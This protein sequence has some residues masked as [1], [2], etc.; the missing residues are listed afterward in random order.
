MRQFGSDAVI[1]L[2]RHATSRFYMEGEAVENNKNWNI[3][4]S[5]DFILVKI[6]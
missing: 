1:S 2:W 4:F 3:G 5:V 6:R